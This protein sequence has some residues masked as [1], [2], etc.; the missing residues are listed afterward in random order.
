MNALFK[1]EKR[2]KETRKE[3]FLFRFLLDKY[4]ELLIFFVI[5]KK[6]VT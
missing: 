4:K 5:K 6:N 2:G 1:F 3:E